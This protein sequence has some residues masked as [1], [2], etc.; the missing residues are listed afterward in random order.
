MA[1][2]LLDESKITAYST[3][4]FNGTILYNVEENYKVKKTSALL[5]VKSQLNAGYPP[6]VKNFVQASLLLADPEERRS[7]FTSSHLTC[8]NTII[9]GTKYRVEIDVSSLGINWQP[10]VEYRFE[11]SEDFVRDVGVGDFQ[12]V[13]P[14]ISLSYTTNPP[15]SISTTNPPTNQTVPFFFSIELIFDRLVKPNNLGGSIFLYRNGALVSTYDILTDVVFEENK[16]KFNI[17]NFILKNSVFYILTTPAAIKDYDNYFW[18]VNDPNQLTFTTTN[19]IHILDY[20]NDTNKSLGSFGFSVGSNNDYCVIGAPFD[21]TNQFQVLSDGRVFIYDMNNGNYLYELNRNL[22]SPPPTW[23]E[24]GPSFTFGYSIGVSQVDNKAVVGCPLYTD[25][26]G[27]Y[28]GIASVWDL[29]QQTIIRNLFP[30]NSNQFGKYFGAAVSITGNNVIVGE[31][32]LGFIHCFNALTGTRVAVFQNP[33]GLYSGSAG[34]S[35]VLDNYGNSLTKLSVFNFFAAGS[36]RDNRV[37]IYNFTN[38]TLH[39]T[40]NGPAGSSLFGKSIDIINEYLVVGSPSENRNGNFAGRV[41]V[42]NINTNQLVYTL[43]NPNLISPSDDKFGFNVKADSGRI[44]VT[45]PGDNKIYVFELLTGILVNTINQAS[46]M[47]NL[48]L[49]TANGRTNFSITPNLRLSIGYKL[50]LTPGSVN[51]YDPTP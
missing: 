23:P 47:L 21:S 39:Q 44:Y 28:R 49:L 9:S 45:A 8:D 22:S 15:I 11:F 20:P 10:N 5:K 51:V 16:I 7:L 26:A 33:L 34:L 32:G 6:F 4:K 19:L 30:L 14:E 18:E 41:Y 2:V 50:G 13:N 1:L 31:P 38:F 25:V 27:Q 46:E 36:P 48:P 29:D 42:Y 24:S 17:E 37:Y 3:N 35:D 12:T 40:I 43:D